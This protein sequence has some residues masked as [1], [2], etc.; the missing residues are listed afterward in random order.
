MPKKILFISPTGTF[1]NGA[2]I[3]IFYLM[4][5]LVQQE[6][7]V[8]NVAPQ[9]N[10]G[11]QTEYYNKYMEAGIKVDFIPILKWWWED[12]PGGLPGTKEDRNAYYRENILKIRQLIQREK[13]DY[14]VTNTVNMFQ[15]AVAAS[16][17]SIPHFWLIHEF[18]TGE[19]GYYREKI[20]FID[21]FSDQIFAVTGNLQIELQ[22]LFPK[23]EIMG[24]ASFTEIR[25]VNQKIGKKTRIVSI[26]RL[27][28]RKNQL[29][30]IKAY[31]QLGQTD[32]ELVFIGAWD[33]EYKKKCTEYIKTHQIK[34]VHFK[35]NKEDPWK[36]VTDQDIC[37]YTSSMETFGL[38]Y[39]E[40]LLNGVPVI[41]SDNPG[42]MSAYNM[43]HLGKIYQ[44]GNEIQLARLIR[45][46]ITNFSNEKSNAVKMIDSVRE[47][48]QVPVVYRDILLA[49]EK[50]IE[51]TK[52]SMRHLADLV[53]SNEQKGRLA[54]FEI[55]ARKFVSK[56]HHRLRR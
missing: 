42:Y 3:S 39:V 37:V 14:V 2:E 16:S 20:D 10:A 34:N 7:E 32:V 29:E 49:L 53:S 22:K 4:K 17:E 38:V 24:F 40:A 48:Y 13:I 43:F 41:I 45:E 8:Y 47:I 52:R 28:Q 54:R 35:G 30:L 33:D 15:G 23:R 26:G 25:S 27:T 50:E 36:E 11:I 55:R 31:Q 44:L 18:P 6:Y 12:A 56:V 5:H 1:D 21:D 46:S 19:F 9:A 51:P